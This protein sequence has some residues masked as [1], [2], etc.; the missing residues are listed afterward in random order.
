[1]RRLC[2]IFLSSEI[3]K[4]E[5]VVIHRKQKC[6]K[7]NK[8]RREKGYKALVR[9]KQKKTKSKREQVKTIGHKGESS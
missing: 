7:R 9:G 4:F 3:N 5:C 2:F 8:K 1:M 6:S